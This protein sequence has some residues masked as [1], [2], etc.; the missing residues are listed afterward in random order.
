MFLRQSSQ[1]AFKLNSYEI[2]P[3]SELQ[4]LRNMLEFL[5]LKTYKEKNY[6]KNKAVRAMLREI[7]LNKVIHPSIELISD[8]DYLNE[9]L[10][11]YLKARESL[12]LNLNRKFS[13]SGS[14]EEL[15]KTIKASN[16]IDELKQL[17]FKIVD[18][19]MQATIMNDFNDTKVESSSASTQLNSGII[20]CGASSFYANFSADPKVVDLEQNVSKTGRAN[21]QKARD[22]RNYIKQLKQAKSFCEKRLNRF[23]SSADSFIEDDQTFEERVK[24]LKVSSFI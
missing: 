7:L 17:H 16:S 5:M 24:K 22:L 2:S 18:E 11:N 14:F 10:L 13:Q 21:S 4:H 6:F 19:I 20:S 23:S 9:K 15:L 1:D 8:P 3:E 12:Q